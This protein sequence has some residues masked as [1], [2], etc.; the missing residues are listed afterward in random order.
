MPARLP[1]F[2]GVVL[3][4]LP[5]FLLVPFAGAQSQSLTG[6]EPEA[7]SRPPGEL[8]SGKA[9]QE[10]IEKLRR[11]S[12]EEIRALDQKLAEALILYYDRKFARALPIF[13]E[14]ADKVETIDIMFWVGTSAMKVGET[15]LAIRNFKKMLAIDPKLHRVRLDLAAAY[16]TMGHY[17]EARRE[18]E[19]VQA[20]A[21]PPGVQ[22]NI[23]R[24]LAA[25]EER[26]RKV[27]W[28]LRLSQ[29]FLWDDNISAGPDQKELAVLGGT[30]TLDKESAELRD[31]AT[32]T[33]VAGNVIY[34]MGERNGLMWNTAASF[35]NLA[36]LDYSDFNY[37]AMD[38]TTGPWWASRRDILKIPFGYTKLEYG[39]ERLSYISHVDPNY[40]H[41]F[42][43]Y[44]SLKGLYSYSTANYYASK[45]SALDY[46]KNRYE[47]TPNIYLLNRKHIM[48]ATAGYEDHNTDADRFTYDGPYYAFSYFANFPT[49]TEF[50]LQYQW[51][52]RDYDG[53]PLLYDKY[54]E[55]K[56]HSFTAVLSQAF[57]KYFFVSF[58]F[59]YTDNDSNCELYDFDRT[60]YTISVGWR[61]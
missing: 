44:F 20:V 36:Y 50:F 27:F 19:L 58:S 61:S 40:E 24:L 57:F 25:I 48:S 51:A 33:N 45:N 8:G 3:L 15:R 32:V 42:N 37:M 52:R 13:K 43:Q 9:N 17:D 54:R 2:C 47:L 56:R 26:T 22:K 29:G 41:Y 59:N 18:L 11:M 28:N 46:R 21:P 10:A 23:A 35:Y 30:L 16:F 34:D 12:K 4:L 39:R 38:V 1:L 5:A 53:R 60:T 49:K 31:E 14:I 6:F 55:D 7:E